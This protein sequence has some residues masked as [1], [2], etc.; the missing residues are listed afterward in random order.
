MQYI[1]NLMQNK[2]YGYTQHKRIK[3]HTN[4]TP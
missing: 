3:C 2:I 4:P 1:D